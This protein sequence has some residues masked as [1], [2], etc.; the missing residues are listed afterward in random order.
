MDRQDVK[1][2]LD[3]GQRKF[4]EIKKNTNQI[5]GNRKNAKV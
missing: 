1:L 5:A 2:M 3:L 4:M